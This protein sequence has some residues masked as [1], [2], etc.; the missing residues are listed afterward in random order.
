VEKTDADELREE[1]RARDDERIAREQ[2]EKGDRR[3]D[4][5]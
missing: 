3:D 4:D 1:T 2:K 5:V